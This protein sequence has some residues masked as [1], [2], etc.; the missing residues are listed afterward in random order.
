[1][2]VSFVRCDTI[3]VL[4]YALE[5]FIQHADDNDPLIREY[6]CRAAYIADTLRVQLSEEIKK[7]KKRKL[8]P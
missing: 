6:I 2:K 3:C 7:R 4:I 1:M 5:Y 8:N